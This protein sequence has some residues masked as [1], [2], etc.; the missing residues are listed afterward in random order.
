MS[1]NSDILS[2]RAEIKQCEALEA[3]N[4]SGGAQS[5]PMFHIV[6]NTGARMSMWFGDVVLDMN[7]VQFKS[8]PIPILF[9]HDTHNPEYGIGHSVNCTVQNG[10]ILID[11]VVSRDTQCA[12]EFVESSK[13][14]FPW[15]ASVGARMLSRKEIQKGET[16]VVNGRLEEGP[17]TIATASEIWE[18]S[19]VTFGADRN[20]STKVTAESNFNSNDIVGQNM[21]EQKIPQNE[22]GLNATASQPENP[23]DIT[24]ELEALREKSAKEFERI[25]Q[26][27][28][29]ATDS[30]ELLVAQAIREGWTPDKFELESLRA[31]R[32]PIPS[33]PKH[34]IRADAKA[35]EVVALR[36][37][38]LVNE[39]KYDEQTL[40]AADKFGNIGFQE[41]VEIACGKQLPRY[42]RNPQEWLHAAFSTQN[43][44]Y[45]LTRSFNAILLEAFYY[46]EAEWRKVFNIGRVGDFKTYDRYRMNPTDF[47][48]EPL[49]DGGKY[50]HGE[51][52]D[53]AYS[54]QAETFGKMYAITRK[55]IINDDMGVFTELPKMIGFG[56]SETLNRYCWSKF[57]NPSTE[58]DTKAFYHADHGNLKTSCAL[59]LEN[60]SAARADFLKQKK[61]KG[62]AKTTGES[63]LGIQPVL[64]VVP[65]ELEDKAL[66]LTKAT[67]FNNGATTYNPADYNPQS[68]RWQIVSSPYLSNSN[69]TG[70]SA[71]TW[72]I[73]ADPR[74]LAAFEI[75]FLN[76]KD[77][78]TIA[79]ADADFDTEGIQFKGYI[80]FGISQ[81]DYRAS[82]KCTA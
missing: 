52:S 18:V 66:M 38:G 5:L 78:P 79:R 60:L 7:G 23:V 65:T 4:E 17:L 61:T 40:E 50:K 53:T 56:A 14:G 51:L 54:V 43:L 9:G 55:D 15:E 34:D 12:K 32:Q 16:A 64:L 28:A 44:S 72:Y 2:L 27:K 73:M 67:W 58:P 29:R 47:E 35:L 30:D 10:N 1:E 49:T 39:S 71:S 11:G 45:V 59:T 42:K 19:V 37:S 33:A 31:N 6:A 76:G 41:F 22:E 46:T 82:M 81:Q 75:S 25:A 63:P 21:D 69:F 68:G 24:A 3:E 80:D 74:R 77:S 57:L 62:G 48:F 20:T 70:Y 36:A 8:D 13:R 26:I